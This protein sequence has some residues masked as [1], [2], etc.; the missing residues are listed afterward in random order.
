MPMAAVSTGCADRSAGPSSPTEEQ[1]YSATAMV[2]ESAGH[3]PQLCLGGVAESYPPQCGGPDV[4][5]WD[6]E[7]VDGEE[8]AAGTT[9]GEYTVTGTWD[10]EQLT[11]TERP[12]RPEP[13]D[14][15]SGDEPFATP[16][17]PPAGGWAVV[18][19]ST[20]TQDHMDTAIEYARAQPTHAGVWLDQLA[21]P[22]QP[23]REERFDPADAVLNMRFT[24]DLERIQREVRELWGGPLCITRAER[25][26]DELLAVQQELH[27]DLDDIL[28]SSVDE[29]QG[30]VEITV[31]VADEELLNR[32]DERYPGDVVEVHGRLQPVP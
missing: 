16:C 11:V 23:V 2:L 5:G 10:G 31:P 29:V 7:A 21:P 22:E 30:V 9:W 14:G 18:D 15:H 19:P 24:G 6:W 1:R 26:L 8:T 3:G 28:G 13:L 20:A 17:E 4:V 32:L 25:T 27:G 12:A